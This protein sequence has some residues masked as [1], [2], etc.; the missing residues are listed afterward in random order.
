MKNFHTKK[1]K[2]IKLWAWAATV[3]PITLLCILF[4]VQI[5]GFDAVK[6]KILVIG[7]TIMFTLSVIWW[8]WA[9]HT[10]GSVTYLLSETLKKFKKVNTE[11]DELKEDIKDIKDT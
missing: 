8:W 2:E 1:L 5:L 7:G 3:L 9:L 11:L 4:L 10:I 6:Q